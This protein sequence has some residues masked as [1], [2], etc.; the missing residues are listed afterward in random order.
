M[1]SYLIHPASSL[2]DYAGASPLCLL[3]R[4]ENFL[5]CRYLDEAALAQLL[6]GG[7]GPMPLCLIL[8]PL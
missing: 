6:F 5:K 3:L 7:A 4:V 8:N 1:K 2:R